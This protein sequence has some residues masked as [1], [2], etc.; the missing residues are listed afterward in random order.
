[1]AGGGARN[2]E[3]GK[4]DGKSS[5]QVET[6]SGGISHQRCTAHLDWEGL[7]TDLFPLLLVAALQLWAINDS[8]THPVTTVSGTGINEAIMTLGQVSTDLT[9]TWPYLGNVG[10]RNLLKEQAM[11]V[12]YDEVATDTCVNTAAAAPPQA[13]SS[14]QDERTRLQARAHMH[15]AVRERRLLL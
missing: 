7:Y 11:N 3:R 12:F 8:I 13:A 10:F 6:S 4:H 2:H 5:S 15:H 1:M 9:P 14:V